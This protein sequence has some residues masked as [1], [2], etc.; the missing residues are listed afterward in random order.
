MDRFKGLLKR[1]EKPKNE[2]LFPICTTQIVELYTSKPADFNFLLFDYMKTFIINKKTY[3]RL[4]SAALFEKLINKIFN[5][6]DISQFLLSKELIHFDPEKFILNLEKRKRKKKIKN[7][8]E[9]K[10]L[11]EMD[12]TK[13]TQ[14]KVRVYLTRRNNFLYSKSSKK[15][16]ST[17]KS[18]KRISKD[19]EEAILNQINEKTDDNLD[20]LKSKKEKIENEI[21]GEN[22]KKLK[23]DMLEDMEEKKIFG[24]YILILDLIFDLC[25]FLIFHHNW[26]LRHGA[27]LIFRSLSRNYK[28]IFSYKKLLELNIIKKENKKEKFN[29]NNLN[30]EDIIKVQNSINEEIKQK[31]LILLSLDRFSDFMSDKSNMTNRALAVE[32]LVITFCNIPNFDIFFY[33]NEI[34]FIQNVKSGWEP[35]QAFIF[36]SKKLIERTFPV[37]GNEKIVDENYYYDLISDKHISSILIQIKKII[38]EHEEI[39]EICAEFFSELCQRKPDFLKSKDLIFFQNKFIESLIKTEDISYLPK[40]V[41]EF[42]LVLLYINKIDNCVIDKMDLFIKKFLFHNNKEVRKIIF[43]FIKNFFKNLSDNKIKH[44]NVDDNKKKFFFFTILFYFLIEKK[45]EEMNEISEIIINI[46]NSIKDEKEKINCLKKFLEIFNY[47]DLSES[48]D[49][50]DS[51]F[52][53]N[54]EKGKKI[55]FLTTFKLAIEIL[56]KLENN[57]LKNLCEEIFSEK[58]NSLLFVVFLN[59][60]DNNKLEIDYYPE[61]IKEINLLKLKLDNFEIPFFNKKIKKGI[62]LCENYFTENL[63]DLT[64]LNIPEIETNV[65]TILNF[66]ENNSVKKNLLEIYNSFVHIFQKLKNE[67]KNQNLHISKTKLTVEIKNSILPIFKE[68]HEFSLFYITLIKC[69]S[70]GVEMKKHLDNKSFPENKNINYLVKPFLEIFKFELDEFWKKLLGE[71]FGRMINIY[72]QKKLGPNKKILSNVVKKLGKEENFKKNVFF[73]FK[74]FFCIFKENTYEKFT[75]FEQV[76]SNPIFILEFYKIFLDFPKTELITKNFFEEKLLISFQNGSLNNELFFPILKDLFKNL[77]SNFTSKNY[78]NMNVFLSY[79]LKLIKNRKELGFKLLL[80]LIK[81]N[82]TDFLLYAKLFLLDII[83]SINEIVR[84]EK[85]II[86]ECF[87]SILTLSYFEMENEAIF[88][89][90]PILVENYKNGKRFLYEFKNNQNFDINLNG[91][92]NPIK[93]FNLRAYQNE[94]I[95][96]I[97]FLFKYGLSGALCDDMGLGKT[98]QSLCAIGL[99]YSDKSELKKEKK[100][101]TEKNLEQEK[102]ENKLKEENDTMVENKW[103]FCEKKVENDSLIICPN[104]LL[105]HW[106]KECIKYINPNLINPVILTKKIMDENSNNLSLIKKKKGV[107]NLYIMT[108]ST[109]IKKIDILKDK[110]FEVVV[111]DEAHMIKNPKNKLS[112]AMKSLNCRLR[113][114]LTGTPIQ[115]NIAELWSI[116]DF[117]MPLYLGNNSSFRKKFRALL[118]LH[119]I[120]LDTNKMELS[121][122]QEKILKDLHIKVLPFIMR[123]EKTEVLKD[124]PPKIIQDFI[125]EMTDVQQTIYEKFEEQDVATLGTNNNEKKEIKKSFLRVLS[126][127]RKIL[128]HPYLLIQKSKNPKNDNK[129]L[130]IYTSTLESITNIKS[131]KK[132]YYISGKFIALKNL[133]NSLNYRETDLLSCSENPKKIL[134]FTRCKKTLNLL[135]KYLKSTFKHLSHLSLL[136]E[137]SPLERN[138]I[139]EKFNLEKSFKMLLLTPKIGGL[140]LNLASAEIVIMFDHDFNPMNDLQA[141]DRAHRL[142]QKKVVNVFR[143]VTRGTLEEKIMGIQKFK[144]SVANTVINYENSSIDNVRKS[145]FIDFLESFASDNVRGEGEKKVL[146]GLGVYAKFL[147][148]SAG[149]ESWDEDEYEK[150]YL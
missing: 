40:S 108:Y 139:V 27:L 118:D 73:Y 30:K 78:K 66:I 105:Y 22:L 61:K 53:Y 57:F 88:C 130:K 113:L 29:I 99:I 90:S 45:N 70:S 103:L 36:L 115:N 101:E 104:S 131:I 129:H 80:E 42:F 39:T 134:L 77:H 26:E 95:K 85:D 150:E 121:N 106:E 14:E 20:F 79:F 34:L 51:G 37:F 8:L 71:F 58:Q 138:E 47:K 62:S 107:N 83:K 24:N 117:L 148:E 120:S 21:T 1:F 141:M 9:Y 72:L 119:L 97:N 56:K 132:D 60:K 93:D 142:G 13:L 94:G 149:N 12:L 28:N 98:I 6:R 75:I 52:F 32:I 123:R 136:Q 74:S 84:F 11:V 4:I 124:L 35:K 46:I 127:L 17:E 7:V 86:F 112:L 49:N 25:K 143:I 65:L 137:H 128:N 54:I 122:N 102:F 3:K 63:E 96:W 125:A 16:E 145:R 55:D 10:E 69:C 33:L 38:I 82:K 109:I 64:K 44:I 67:L 23:K 89:L 2:E 91:V 140:G 43:M 15:L 135:Q 147:K 100:S 68:L 18:S 31:C 146:K 87:T 48:I 59:L 111:L 126:N 110:K 116:F 114:G 76:F 19:D 41:F 144:L 92:L 5:N 50:I 81:E 133:L